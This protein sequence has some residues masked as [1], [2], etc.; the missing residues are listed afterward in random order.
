MQTEQVHTHSVPIMIDVEASGFGKGSYPLEIGV[1]LSDGTPHCFLLMPARGWTSWD[2]EAEKVHGISRDTVE[3]FGR[4]V[5][6]VAWRLNQLLRGKTVYSDAWAFDLSW[7]GKLFDKI[8]LQP[9]FRVAAIEDLLS[10]AQKAGWADARAQV[11]EELNLARHR[12]S[13]DARILR[14][15]YLKTLNGNV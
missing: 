6:E 12:A 15:T 3:S 7:L 5:E 2:P 4:P 1:V 13:G 14:E 9:T 11:V 10:E 8:D